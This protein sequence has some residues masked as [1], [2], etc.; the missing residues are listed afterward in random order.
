MG[1]KET[2][3]HLI[4]RVVPVHTFKVLTQHTLAV[5]FALLCFWLTAELAKKLFPTGQLHDAIVVVEGVGLI[6]LMSWLFIK[7]FIEL[8]KGGDGNGHAIFAA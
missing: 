2:L 7:M 6:L 8:V 3:K 4:S 5:G 1:W